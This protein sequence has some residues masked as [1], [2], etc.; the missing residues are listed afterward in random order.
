MARKLV[1]SIVKLPLMVKVP[2]VMPAAALEVPGTTVAELVAETFPVIV[3]NAFKADPG[4]LSVGTVSVTPWSTLSVPDVI[5]MEVRLVSDE[6]AWKFK[7]ELSEPVIKPGPVI[8]PLTS[9]LLPEFTSVAPEEMM[10]EPEPEVRSN[11]P[12]YVSVPVSTFSIPVFTNPMLRVAFEATVERWNVPALLNTGAGAPLPNTPPGFC[13]SNVVPTAWCHPAPFSRNKPAPPVIVTPLLLA[14]VVPITT[15]L[16]LPIDIPPVVVR[17]P[18]SWTMPPLNVNN[19]V[20]VRLFVPVSVPAEKVR[21]GTVIGFVALEKF[22]VPAE[23]VSGPVA[24]RGPV[25]FAIPPVTIVA[26]VTL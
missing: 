2:G 19:P 20:I 9:M 7:F 13:T 4:R 26:P 1:E 18:V 21:L 12:L 15:A 17:E 5:V 14:T 11:P 24:V 23:M 10:I 16:A 3:P 6:P 8:A 22:A 25:K